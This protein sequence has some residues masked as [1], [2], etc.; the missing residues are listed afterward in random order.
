MWIDWELK[1]LDVKVFVAYSH[2]CT[3]SCRLLWRPVW[4]CCEC[5]WLQ[6]MCQQWNLQCN[7]PLLLHLHLSKRWGVGP[8]GQVLHFIE[9]D[10]L[11]RTLLTD[12]SHF[13]VSRRDCCL[14]AC[15]I[16]FLHF[17]VVERLGVDKI[18]PAI[19]PHPQICL[20]LSKLSY[21]RDETF[22]PTIRFLLFHTLQGPFF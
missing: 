21:S 14:V 20:V 10:R 3:A 15:L 2:A 18:Y 13:S 5:L 19:T 9:D 4:E 12:P 16:F 1:L 8:P 6:P 11:N 17:F 7:W 22:L